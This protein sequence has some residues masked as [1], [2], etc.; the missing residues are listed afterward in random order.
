MIRFTKRASADVTTPAANKVTLFIDDTGLV[1]TKN[2]SGTVAA[3]GLAETL[4]D[5]KGDILAATAADA[6]SRLAVGAND[7]VLTADSAQATG[8]KWA[9]PT[10]N[11]L[12]NLGYAQATANQGSIGG[13]D[14][15]LTSLS[16]TVTVTAGHRIKIIGHVAFSQ[17]SASGIT[18]LRIKEGATQLA[19][20]LLSATNGSYY[21]V[22]AFVVLS[23]SAGSHTYK[24]AMTASPGTATMEA[25]ATYPAFILVEDLGVAV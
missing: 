17:A 22:D 7:T 10:G 24:L 8:L 25:G 13:S 16:V 3:V 5:A 12:G 18:R 4:V 19:D 20:S 11:V 1:K 2:E 14:V 15:D 6:V 9:T 21:S 23:P